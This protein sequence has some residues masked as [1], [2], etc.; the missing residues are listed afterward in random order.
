MASLTRDQRGWCRLRLPPS[1]LAQAA[2]GWFHACCQRE[3]RWEGAIDKPTPWPQASGPNFSR[4]PKPSRRAGRTNTRRKEEKVA[5]ARHQ[6]E[7]HTTAFKRGR[8]LCGGGLGGCG[9][10]SLRSDLGSEGR[11]LLGVG[12]GLVREPAHRQKHT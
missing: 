8:A 2:L 11:A 3:L 6:A 1:Q 9:G 12:F 10:G 4:A 7:T 5:R